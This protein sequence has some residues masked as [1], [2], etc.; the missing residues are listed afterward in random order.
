MPPRGG[1]DEGSVMTFREAEAYL[2]SFIGQR[3]L[4][5]VYNTAGLLEFMKFLDHLGNPHQQL[6]SILVAGTKGKGSTAAMLASMLHAAG[7]KVGL[8]TSPHLCSIRERIQVN[9]RHIEEADF[10]RLVSQLRAVYDAHGRPEVKRFRTFFELL[11]ALAFLHFVQERVDLAVLEVGLGGRL[12]ATNVVVPAVS[13]LTS[14]SLDHVEILGENLTLIARE[15]AGIIKNQGIALSAP[16][17][18]EVDLVLQEMAALQEARLYRVGQ[19]FTWREEACSVESTRFTFVGR[20]HRLQHLAIPLLGRHQI[21]NAVTALAAVELLEEQGLAITP[22]QIRQGL[23]QVRWEGRL[24]IVRRAPWVVL[25]G[26]HNQDS[27]EKLASAVQEIFPYSRLILILGV[28]ANKN[29]QAIV[30]ALAP[31]ADLVITTR[32]EVYRAADP[33]L[34]ARYVSETSTPVRVIPT[35]REA[36][37]E[38]L[39]LTR[40]ADM[41]LI[42]GSLYLIGEV[43]GFWESME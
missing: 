38:G 7:L 25:D 12:D 29:I 32:A 36:V 15:K 39:A 1:M 26:A 18:P 42:T 11:T 19:E 10:A 23:A 34:I 22:A 20:R 6:R 27:A 31:L 14:I 37:E 33:A 41:L 3:K 16:Q 35:A 8:Y 17:V 24:E 30:Q 21:V 28:S 43:K 9:G 2:Y 4:T 13:I 40:Q 5:D